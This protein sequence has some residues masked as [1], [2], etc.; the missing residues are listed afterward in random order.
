[1]TAYLI[2]REGDTDE[3][4]DLRHHECLHLGHVI[5]SA[6]CAGWLAQRLLPGHET[7]PGGGGWLGRAQRLR[8][9]GPS[10]STVTPYEIP[11]GSQTRD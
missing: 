9:E 3:S 7:S 4:L 11:R 5:R 6:R 2:G 1:V 10:N 8:D